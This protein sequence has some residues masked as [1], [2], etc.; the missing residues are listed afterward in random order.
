MGITDKKLTTEIENMYDRFEM[1]V[2][3]RIK[4]ERKRAK[5]VNITK[6]H[7]YLNLDRCSYGEITLHAALSLDPKKEVG[8]PLIYAIDEKCSTVYYN[9][10]VYYKKGCL[11][12][13]C[14][15]QSVHM[16]PREFRCYP[17]SQFHAKS[18]T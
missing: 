6:V 17:E 9:T 10:D 2:N 15:Y 8:G 7:Y 11:G 14:P 16:F 3:A 13:W 12:G 1:M 4:K 5:R 18:R